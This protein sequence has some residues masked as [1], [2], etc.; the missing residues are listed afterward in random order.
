MT[1]T[2]QKIL[3]QQN[4]TVAS[5]EN[6]LSHLYKWL[7]GQH[8][9]L[10]TCRHKLCPCF[11]E[12]VAQK[13]TEMVAK[14]QEQMTTRM[15]RICCCT[16]ALAKHAKLSIF[17]EEL[18]LTDYTLWTCPHPCITLCLKT[19]ENRWRI[20][21]NLP[22]LPLPNVLH[23]LL[24]LKSCWLIGLSFK[25]W[26]KPTKEKRCTESKQRRV[27]NMLLA[28][29]PSKACRAWAVDM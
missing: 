7:I 29:P 1:H 21:S 20:L 4:L 5:R 9:T 8:L 19:R 23:C 11:A 26:Q 16:F 3:G 13:A 6:M 24:T 2:L 22:S 27:V 25:S 12:K 14:K 18:L 17:F 10:W 28:L 15:Q